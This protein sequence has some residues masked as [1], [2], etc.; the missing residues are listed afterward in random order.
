MK[1]GKPLQR[2]SG[3]K[4]RKRLEAD[5]EKVR[6]FL[7]RGKRGPYQPK[8][9]G[10]TAVECARPGCANVVERY[11]SDLERGGRYCSR[12]CW[13]LDSSE[14]RKRATAA[15]AATTR[16]RK[17]TSN[18]AYRHGQRSGVRDR[19]GERRFKSG[20]TEC[21]HPRCEDPRTRVNEHHVVYE[22]HVRRAGGD[23]WDPRNALALCVPC[24]MSHHRRGTKIVPLVAL[25]D[26]NYAFAFELL[27][28]AA[29][30]YLRRRYVGDDPR[31]HAW[32]TR[33]EAAAANSGDLSRGATDGEGQAGR[34]DG[35]HA[36]GD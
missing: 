6:E 36:I 15:A 10:K 11:A 35:Y 18:P 7:R 34:R 12:E 14:Q 30:D 22:Q 24:H 5:P 27:G 23:R 21:V 29:F 33:V 4:T 16:D 32:L 20:Q 19:A 9:H 31:L 25:R 26:E 1:R 13:R 2:R 17:G 28:A 3:L 8:R